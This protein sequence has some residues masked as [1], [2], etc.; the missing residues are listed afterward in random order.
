MFAFVRDV[1]DAFLPAYLPIVERRRAEPCGERERHFQLLRRGRYVEFNLLYDRGTVFGLKT[2]G[3]IE[4]ILMSLPPVTRWEYDFAPEP[5]S[6]EAASLDAI[7]SKAD[8]ASLV[9]YLTG[10][11]SLPLA[12]AGPLSLRA[13][14]PRCARSHSESAT[15]GFPL[16]EVDTAHPFRTIRMFSGGIPGGEFMGTLTLVRDDTRGVLTDRQQAILDFITQSIDERGYPP[17]LREIGEHFGIRSTN[18]VND[19]LNALEKKGH[20][21]REDLKSRALRPV[22]RAG[23]V[24]GRG[25]RP[26]GE[27]IRASTTWSRSR[28]SG[29]SPPACRCS[30]SRTCRTPCTSTGSSSARRARSSRC[31]SRANR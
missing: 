8:W 31:A 27:P 23:V 19:H 29:A 28:S 21:Q 5:G 30:P 16:A 3:R 14:K 26:T 20:L 12:P 2:D 15:R 9:T 10:D 6:V 4:S 18:G 13:A 11:G 24:V 25:R 17:T 1:G 7:C 22:G